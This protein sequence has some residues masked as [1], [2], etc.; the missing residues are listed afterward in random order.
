MI[1]NFG[2]F[3]QALYSSCNDEALKQN[4]R[5]KAFFKKS[6][7]LTNQWPKFGTCEVV[8]FLVKL[9]S[10]VAIMS[11]VAIT[12]IVVNVTDVIVLMSL[13]LTL[14]LNQIF[15]SV[16]LLNWTGKCLR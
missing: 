7:G 2:D 8:Y 12:P 11:M 5:D 3:T 16:S 15:F 9:R 4:V 14:I 13:M 10:E 1:K 6:C